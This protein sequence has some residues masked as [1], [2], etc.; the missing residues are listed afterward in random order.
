ME[1]DGYYFRVGLFVMVALVC[2]TTVISWFASK[3]DQAGHTPYVVYFSGSVD[4]LVH[5]A[6]VK[7]RGIQV[8]YVD[9]IGFAGPSD[10]RIRVL[11]QLMPE[12]PVWD[13]TMAS[14]QMQGLT[15]GS[16]VALDNTATGTLPP[17]GKDKDGVM[18][19]PSKP[20]SLEKVFSSVPQ[21]LEEY[22]KLAVQAQKLL[23]DENVKSVHDALA[24]MGGT[25]RG[26]NS[27]M[28]SIG[29]FFGQQKGV[30]IKQTF[31]TLNDMIEEAKTALREVRMLA[32]T[33]RE[34][35]SIVI[36]GTQHEGV[37]LP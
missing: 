21:M 1:Q 12:A 18:I 13:T 19:I 34:D 32:R 16:M 4:G 25:V 15:G 24:L 11:V 14:L 17:K 26:I 20:S 35:P 29:G 30:D 3:H 37:K 31:A 5:G 6:P 10:D 28:D 27:T 9:T 33:L 8:G 7:L 2:A 23:D 36:H 22:T